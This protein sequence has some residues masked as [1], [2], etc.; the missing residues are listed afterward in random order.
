M[1]A[2]TAPTNRLFSVDFDVLKRCAAVGAAVSTGLGGFRGTPK[3]RPVGGFR[4]PVSA[5]RMAR[6]DATFDSVFLDGRY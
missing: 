4:D 5:L 3:D 1:A 2:D 6:I